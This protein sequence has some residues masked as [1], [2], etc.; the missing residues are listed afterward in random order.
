M[1]VVE[2]LGKNQKKSALMTDFFCDIELL[3]QQ[4][5]VAA[6]SFFIIEKMKIAER[7]H[8]TIS[9]PQTIHNGMPVPQ[10]RAMTLVK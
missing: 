1:K 8:S 2:R 3:H 9:T 4:S 7:Q 6:S 5:F 10:M